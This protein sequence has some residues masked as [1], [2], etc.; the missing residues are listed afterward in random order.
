MPGIPAHPQK[1]PARSSTEFVPGKGFHTPPQTTTAAAPL[2]GTQ[3]NV[4][5]NPVLFAVDQNE[6]TTV[7]VGALGAGASTTVT[8]QLGFQLPALALD[9]KHSGTLLL[10]PDVYLAP[11]AAGLVIASVQFT[12]QTLVGSTWSNAQT[13]QPGQTY[14][15][16]RALVT[17]GLVAVTATAAAQ[18][19]IGA[20]ASLL[21]LN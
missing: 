1:T 10:T 3:G 12:P 4:P 8:T 17:V 14:T 13:M 2:L 18:V 15:A 20:K 19:H 21:V 5:A 9:L 6:S 11:I 16:F 7:A